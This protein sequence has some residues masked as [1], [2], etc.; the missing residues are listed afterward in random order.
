VEGDK[1][2]MRTEENGDVKWREFQVVVMT[3]CQ[4]SLEYASFTFVLFFVYDWSLANKGSSNS[5]KDFIPC[6]TF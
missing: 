5:E 6:C 1:K 3:W 4:S 2:Q